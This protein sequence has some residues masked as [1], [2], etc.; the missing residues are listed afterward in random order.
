MNI[1]MTAHQHSELRRRLVADDPSLDDRT[2]A[3]T[4]EG[5][6]DLKEMLAALVRAALEDEAL[7]MGLKLRLDNMRERLTR[8]QDRASKRRQVARDVMVETET[9]NI[10]APDF[11]VSVRAG[12]PALVVFEETAIPPSYWEPQ[13]PRLNRRSLLDE[14]KQGTIVAGASLSN[15]EPVLSVRTR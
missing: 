15:P 13:P 2:L 10:I 12:S 1:E 4:L 3:D 8:L 11:T 7:A 9:R 6:T 14:L 5:L